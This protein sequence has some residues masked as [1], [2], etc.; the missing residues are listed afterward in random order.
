LAAT[1]AR[2]IISDEGPVSTEA[3]F[4]RRNGALRPSRNIGLRASESVRSGSF[5]RQVL[6]PAPTLSTTMDGIQLDLRIPNST[7]PNP[8]KYRAK[9]HAGTRPFFGAIVVRPPARV[10]SAGANI[11]NR[12]RVFG[13]C[14]RLYARARG[15]RINEF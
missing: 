15:D 9:S 8:I 3:G 14:P 12:G 10:R 6:R 5:L 1:L 11:K 2:S 4:L 7:P 13:F